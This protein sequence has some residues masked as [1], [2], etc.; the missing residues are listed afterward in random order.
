[1][2]TLRATVILTKASGKA[3]DACRNVWHFSTGAAIQQ[4]DEE[5]VGNSLIAF[6][7]ALGSILGASLPRNAAVH[8][9]ELAEVTRGLP[10]AADDTVST[11]IGTRPFALDLAAVGVIDMPSEVA[12]ALSF[13]GDVVGLNEQV[14]I[15]RPKSRRRGRIFLGPVVAAAGVREAVT[16]RT[17]V[18]PDTRTAITNAYRDQL[19]EGI[20]G[21]G[22]IVNHIVY[23]PTSAQVT[24]VVVAHVDDAF[25]TI[26]SRGEKSLERTTQPVVQPPLIP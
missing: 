5:V 4:E 6:Y 26:R 15:I 1:M 2:A 11:L 19:I 3:E 14:G 24:P 23:S 25:D 10:G 17:R 7:K 21:P 16:L 13:R 22:R 18:H 20:N 9:I 8:R 12:I